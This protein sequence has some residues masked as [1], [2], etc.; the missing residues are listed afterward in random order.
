MPAPSAALLAAVLGLTGASAPA[1]AAPPKAEPAG[2]LIRRCVAAYGGEAAL[3]R[4]AAVVHEGS[5]TSIQHPGRT[6]RI[7][8]AFARPGRLRVEITYPGEAGGEIRVLDGARGWRDGREA[9][10][11]PLQAMV[12]QAARLDLVALLS[13]RADA[14]QDRGTL[15]LEGKTLRVLAVAV[16]PGL[17]VE[18][19]LDPSTARIL[20]SRSASTVEPRIEFVTT[21]ADFK[22]VEGVLVPFREGN[23][24]NGKT[25]GE[26]VLER[27]VF[28]PAHDD[29]MFR[30]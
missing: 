4:S 18:A 21:Y 6:G 22:T 10:G 29:A 14:V 27:V 28:V 1:R 7:G 8:R 5:V 25:T 19:A 9:A 12:L 23:W 3:A 2:A 17:E 11:P 26:T 20:R 15:A 24:A 30:P 13:A 16:A